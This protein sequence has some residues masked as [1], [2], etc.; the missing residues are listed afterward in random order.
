[1]AEIQTLIK[2]G[3]NLVTSAEDIAEF[4]DFLYKKKTITNKNIVDINSVEDEY[5]EIFK[6]ISDIPLDINTIAKL[7]KI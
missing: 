5:K 4:Y 6:Y 3:A 7:S 1:M 2:N